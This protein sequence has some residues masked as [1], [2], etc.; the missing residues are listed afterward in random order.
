MAVLQGKSWHNYPGSFSINGGMKKK[1]R[2]GFLAMWD[3]DM[4]VWKI[5]QSH[6]NCIG[7]I[8]APFHMK[9]TMKWKILLKYFE[10]ITLLLINN[11]I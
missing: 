2:A 8:I 9:R 5:D 1:G 4:D 10:C 3:S 7:N 6:G 11:L